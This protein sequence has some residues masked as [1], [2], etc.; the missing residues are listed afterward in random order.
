MR[1]SHLRPVF[2]SPGPFA[3]AYVRTDRSVPT[4]AREVKVRARHVAE[5]LTQQGAPSKAADALEA[6]ITE[7]ADGA[8]AERVLVWADGRIVF[9]AALP[10]GSDEEMITWEPLPRLLTYVRAYANTVPHVVA[11]V[12]R[13]G[14]DLIAVDA[15][16]QVR[17]VESVDGDTMHLR[18]V[19]V[20]DWAHL[21]YLHHV[22]EHWKANAKEVAA[23]VDRLIEEVAAERLVVAGDVRA[24]EKLHDKLSVRSQ[25]LLTEIDHGGRGGK[26]SGV[27]E[28]AFDQAVHEQLSQTARAL[29]EQRCAMF[30]QRLGKSGAAAQGLPDVIASASQAQL[31]TL[32]VNE[33]FDENAEAWIGAG[34]VELALSKQTLQTLGADVAL[35]APVG[36]ALLRAAVATDAEVL[37]VPDETLKL[38]D[39]IGAL[40][41][42]S[43]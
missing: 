7:S 32:L 30:T 31:D 18:K 4:A 16:G 20:G 26:E 15:L 19:K 22:E 1:L 12:D 35:T 34:N 11:V 42:Y 37:V 8:P 28:H 13:V 23:A 21:R 29:T 14:G 41:R 25:A 40:L 10:E 39:G 9:D 33:S 36:S 38:R 43:T 24:R 5:R 17:E 6:A 3:T 2:E 27:D